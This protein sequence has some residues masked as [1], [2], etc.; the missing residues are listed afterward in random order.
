[1]TESTTGQSP[2]GLDLEAFHAWYDAQRPGDLGSPLTAELIAG[3]RSNLTYVVTDG[4]TSR[5]VRRQPLGHVQATAHDMGRE[6][7]VITA[8]A[9]TDVPVPATYASCED[10]SVI[11]APF[12]VMEHVR[13]TPYRSKAQLEDLGRPTT[14][15]I[16]YAMVD[17]LAALHAVDYE[18][19]GLGGFGRPE[20]FVGR[21]VRRWGQQL[22]GSH[23]REL[24]GAAELHGELTRRAPD[25]ASADATIV[26]GDYRLDNLLVDPAREGAEVRAVVD[27]EMATLGDPLTD[28]ALLA[29]YDELAGMEGSGLLVTDASRA[30][31]FPSTEEQLQRYAARSGRDLGEMSFHLGLAY[32]KL[33]VILEGIHYRYLQ[34]QTVGEGFDRVG[35][36]VEPLLGAGLDAL[37]RG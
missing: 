18:A 30:A 17:T 32:F 31:G 22:E 7:T 29:V 26:H 21:Q 2:K 6:H 34:G 16:A 15:R 14:E 20:G 11:G 36:A 12:Y 3:G 23:S 10:P 19:V 4:S 27:W 37:R 1:V 8:L 28:L 33:A 24:A 5:I 9:G 35:E 25:A 13:G